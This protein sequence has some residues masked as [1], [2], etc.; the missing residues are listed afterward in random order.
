[1]R[2]YRQRLLIDDG[3]DLPLFSGTPGRAEEPEPIPEVSPWVQCSPKLIPTP[4]MAT[5]AAEIKQV[6]ASRNHEA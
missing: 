1:M 5:L 3:S 4:D 6:A 2:T